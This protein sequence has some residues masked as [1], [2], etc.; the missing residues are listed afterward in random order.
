MRFVFNGNYTNQEKEV[1]Q[2]AQ[3]EDFLKIYDYLKI[4]PASVE[5]ITYKVFDSRK[6]KQE[7]DP[8]HSI[9]R[10]SARSGEMAVY[11][12]WLPSDDSHFPHELTHL[13]TAKWGKSYDWTLEVDTYDGKKITLTEPMLSTS[14]MQEGLAIA[15]DDIVFGRKLMEED[16]EKFIDDWCREYK[17]KFP[18]LAEC[19]NMD[20]FCAFENKL[21]V[22]FTASLSKFLLRTFG[23]EKFRQVYISLNELVPPADNVKVMENVFGLKEKELI[24]KWGESIKDQETIPFHNQLPFECI[25]GKL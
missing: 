21:I 24:N 14:F 15:V 2:K 23:I 18:K 7:A 5:K 16:E 17:G 9:S 4:N 13:A 10:A 12:F 3:E 8:N 11:R 1:F 22:P 20:G 19:I 6:G 25:K